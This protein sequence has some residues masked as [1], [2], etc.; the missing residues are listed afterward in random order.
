MENRLFL[1]QFFDDIRQEVGN[2]LS[3]IGC[4]TSGDMLF[5]TLPAAL[6]KVCVY[7]TA[8]APLD[9]PFE[10]LIFRATINGDLLAEMEV[11]PDELHPAR[12]PNRENSDASRLGITAVMAFSPLYIAEPCTLKIEAETE[13]GT[14]NA[15][16]LFIR[17]LDLK[18]IE[19]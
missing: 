7:L 11:P 2:K 9:Q 15:G 4:Y 3:M 17:Q 1:A 12:H 14:L 10:K 19:A 5:E 6:P 8:L 18:N 16:C 13:R